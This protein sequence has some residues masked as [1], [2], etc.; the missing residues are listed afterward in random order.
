MTGTSVIALKYKDG[1]IMACDTGGWS[2][3]LSQINTIIS[4]G[5]PSLI[6]SLQPP[7]DQL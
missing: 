7:M 1:V 2:H 4:M 5:E 6:F 3:F